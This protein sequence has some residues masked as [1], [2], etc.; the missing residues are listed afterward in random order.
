MGTELQ[1]GTEG[2][3]AELTRLTTQPIALALSG[4]Y[5]KPEI[6]ARDIAANGGSVPDLIAAHNRALAPCGNDWLQKRLRL[7][8]KSSPVGGSIDATAWLHETGRLLAD[9]PQDILAAA[10]DQAVMK[11]E[12][13][14][15]P[16][17]GEIRALAEPELAKRRLAKWRLEQVAAHKRTAPVPPTERCS[18]EQAAAIL[19]EVGVNTNTSPESDWK[20]KLRDKFAGMQKQG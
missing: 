14:F 19:K 2:P 3:L 5:W 12:R 9:L 10:I 7:L 6:A 16:G 8:W 18:P 17:V 1:T 20:S 11:S 13:G 15:M 4:D